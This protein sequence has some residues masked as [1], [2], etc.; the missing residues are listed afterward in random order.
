MKEKLLA[1]VAS[2]AVRKSFVAL[3]LAVLGA[4]GVSYSTGC[5]MLK[6]GPEAQRARVDLF[7]CQVAAVEPLTDG[8][9][10]SEALVLDLYAGKADLGKVLANLNASEAEVAALLARLHAC[11]PAPVAPPAEGVVQ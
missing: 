2:P 8:V 4:L 5:A 10:D 6:S 1:L 11:Q 7:K 9:L 3:V